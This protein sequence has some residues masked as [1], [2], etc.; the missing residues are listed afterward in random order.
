MIRGLLAAR[1]STEGSTVDRL[2]MAPIVIGEWRFDRSL[3]RLSRR[4]E[5]RRLEPKVA[6]VLAVLIQRAGE[7]VTRDDLL[8][9]V[10]GDSSVVDAVLTRAISELRK[11]LGDDPRQPRYLETIPRRGYR[12]VAPV[13]TPE[14]SPL[15]F[16]TLAVLPFDDL[17]P[18]RDQ[19][20][21]AH[22]VTEMLITNLAKVG[23]L[24]VTS[25]TSVMRLEGSDRPLP[26]IASPAGGRGGP[27]GHG[28]RG[29][30]PGAGDG[31]AHRSVD[32]HTPVGGSLRP[33]LR[34]SVAAPG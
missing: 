27:G 3:S 19:L 17:S 31:T 15:P 22:G 2:G 13:R 16:R 6:D 18:G 24:R 14:D 34:R 4:G 9:A 12:L 1:E 8:T 29:G 23:G 11:A 25:R 5:E 28:E 32:G 21:V 7:V 10:W 20:H 30:R 26:D 33:A